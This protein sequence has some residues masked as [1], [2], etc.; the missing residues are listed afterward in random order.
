MKLKTIITIQLALVA[1]TGLANT[2]KTIKSPVAM[3]FILPSFLG[4]I[5]RSAGSGEAP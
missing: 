4:S 2:Y 5:R 3:L 1:M